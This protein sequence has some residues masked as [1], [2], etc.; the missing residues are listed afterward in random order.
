[1]VKNSAAE[2]RYV[3]TAKD[4]AYL[5]ESDSSYLMNNPLYD[6]FI[7]LDNNDVLGL[8]YPN[9]KEKISLLNL[10]SESTA[11]FILQNIKTR[12]KK[13]IYAS[14]KHINYLF[15]K[16]WKIYIKDDN[17]NISLVSELNLDTK[18]GN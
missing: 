16:D 18:D 11:R 7:V 4:G 8:V 6:D 15:L 13:L 1:M 17:W 12:E 3:I 14:N 10:K 9:S 5:Y 2:N